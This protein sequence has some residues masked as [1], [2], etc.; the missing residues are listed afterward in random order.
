MPKTLYEMTE[1]E[2]RD[3]MNAMG[4]AI[5]FV[6]QH[7]GIERPHFALLVFNDP[8]IAQYVANCERGDI[9]KAMR[10]CADRLE[11]KQDVTR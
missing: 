10:E 5:E 6:A 7:K 4:S 9:I 11:L 2:L 1:P 8:Q 3:L